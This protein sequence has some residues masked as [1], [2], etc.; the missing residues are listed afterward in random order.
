[1]R[2]FPKGSLH[3]V[4]NLSNPDHTRTLDTILDGRTDAQV[5]VNNTLVNSKD[6]EISYLDFKYPYAFIV[7][8]LTENAKVEEQVPVKTEPVVADTKL[9]PTA[10]ES[11]E[12]K[13]KRIR[14]EMN[15]EAEAKRPK[16]TDAPV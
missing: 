15:A 12:A 16:K 5:P 3:M 13:N 10:G 8:N 1:M 11:F 9:N 14:D 6:M 7:F 4:I 2:K